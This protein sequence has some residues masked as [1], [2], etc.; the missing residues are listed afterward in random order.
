MSYIKLET[1]S[2]KLKNVPKEILIM[3]LHDYVKFKDVNDID[4]I[5]IDTKLELNLTKQR[6]ALDNIDSHKNYTGND[7]I[8]WL[9]NHQEWERLNKIYDDLYKEY[10][11]LSKQRERN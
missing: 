10:E 3:M 6:Q 7:R 4:N 11:Q 1:L 9:K 8:E 2:E 5:I